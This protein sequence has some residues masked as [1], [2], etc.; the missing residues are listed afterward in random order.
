MFHAAEHVSSTGP[1]K[2]L[3]ALGSIMGTRFWES[4]EGDF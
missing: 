2:V 1:S 4:A 3:P